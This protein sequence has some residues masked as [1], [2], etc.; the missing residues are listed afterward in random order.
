M[1]IILDT[2]RLIPENPKS[3]HYSSIPYSS[4]RWIKN[5]ELCYF[6]LCYI[7][8]HLFVFVCQATHREINKIYDDRIVF[9]QQQVYS[10]ACKQ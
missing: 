5:F 7:Y 8:S 3:C 6:L 2:T 1:W 9:Y 4:I 10:V